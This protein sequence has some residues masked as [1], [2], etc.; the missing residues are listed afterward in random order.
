MTWFVIGPGFDLRMV[1]ADN[2]NA[3]Y[4]WAVNQWNGETFAIYNE[5]SIPSVTL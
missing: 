2:Y 1:K 3:V 5:D 4:D